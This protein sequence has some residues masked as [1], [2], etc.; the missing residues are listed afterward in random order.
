MLA[1]TAQ[2]LYLRAAA[3]VSDRSNIPPSRLSLYLPRTGVKKI[4]FRR[5]ELFQQKRDPAP[6]LWRPSGCLLTAALAASEKLLE[7]KS[8]LVSACA[9]TSIAR[10]ASPYVRLANAHFLLRISRT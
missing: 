10:L 8:T 9:G 6:L 1:G 4:M 3:H 5:I 7:A 2:Q